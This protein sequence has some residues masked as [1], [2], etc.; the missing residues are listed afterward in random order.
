VSTALE[1]PRARRFGSAAQMSAA[2]QQALHTS[3]PV[4]FDFFISYVYSSLRYLRPIYIVTVYSSLEYEGCSNFCSY[5][6]KTESEF[7]QSLFKC[8]NATQLPAVAAEGVEP[9]QRVVAYLDKA[10]LLD[11]EQF[12]RGFMD[13][14]AHSKV[15]GPLLSAGCV[16]S[17]QSLAQEDRVDFVLC[18]WIMALELHRRGS[19]SAVFPVIVGEQDPQ[20]GRY[21]QTF[22]QE[23]LSGVAGGLGRCFLP[24]VASAQTNTA[25]LQYLQGLHAMD[26]VTQLSEAW[27]VRGVVKAMLQFQ[28]CLLHFVDV[29]LVA[30]I[31]SMAPSSDDATQSDARSCVISAICSDRIVPLIQMHR[32][33]SHET[34]A[35]SEPQRESSSP[36]D[37]QQITTLAELAEAARVTRDRLLQL[38]DDTLQEL[39]CEK[40]VGV[41][42][43][44]SIEREIRQEKVAL[45]SLNQMLEESREARSSKVTRSFSDYLPAHASQPVLSP[46]ETAAAQPL[47]R[48][49]SLGMEDDFVDLLG[50]ASFDTAQQQGEQEP[51]PQPSQPAAAFPFINAPAFPFI[52]APASPRGQARPDGTIAINAS[53]GGL[54]SFGPAS[55]PEREAP[56][57]GVQQQQ[58]QQEE[59]CIRTCALDRTVSSSGQT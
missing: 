24:D 48:S 2:L 4:V 41:M 55:T 28:A 26:S 23:L 36:P 5:R 18:E 3:C 22:F 56:V 37:Q 15:F 58:Q 1:K 13:A 25:A 54:S 10:R 31:K 27:T 40:S 43:K 14:L 8:L 49:R 19:I 17:F 9:E 34:S 6:V 38:P 7:A 30:Q 12:D 33:P 53:E 59:D 45:Q 39:L 44:L 51:S 29:P 47:C 20:S 52:N 57:A 32:N 50:L 46:P 21:T 16:K 35:L 42:E 11:G